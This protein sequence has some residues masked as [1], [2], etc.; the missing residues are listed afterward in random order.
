MHLGGL[1][2]FP[3][4]YPIFIENYWKNSYN[5]FVGILLLAHSFVIFINISKKKQSMIGQAKFEKNANFEK[6][7]V[8]KF[9][10]F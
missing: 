10:K 6:K 5:I 8:T 3:R 9:C 7:R 4:R 2:N 1:D